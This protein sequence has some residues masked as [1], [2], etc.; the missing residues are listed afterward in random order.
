MIPRASAYLT[1]DLMSSLVYSLGL[2]MA[3]LCYAM[4]RP[5]IGIA[6]ACVAIVLVSALGGTAF[7]LRIYL[8]AVTVWALA[9]IGA[10][11]PTRQFDYT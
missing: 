10:A 11:H 8:P 4:G 3:G 5:K 7:E 9:G 1:T 6:L 2:A